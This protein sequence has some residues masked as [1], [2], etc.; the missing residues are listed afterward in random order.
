[1]AAAGSGAAGTATVRVQVKSGS[2]WST[3][4]GAQAIADAKGR[5]AIDVWA[6][7]RGVYTLRV[8]GTLGANAGTSKLVRMTVR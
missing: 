7:R 5:Y 6:Q 2:S 4:P 8:V 1:M 3:I